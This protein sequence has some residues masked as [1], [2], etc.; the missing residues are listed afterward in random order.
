V[1]VEIDG[2]LIREI[3]DL[4]KFF[5]VEESGIKQGLD[6]IWDQIIRTSVREKKL[7]E[8]L[9]MHVK[10]GEKV[11]SAMGEKASENWGIT[12]L[13]VVIA[14]IEPDPRVVED[15]ALKEREKLQREGQIIELQHFTNRVTELMASPPTGA[16][17]SREQ[18][19]EQVQ[20]SLGKATKN[21]DA[22]TI[23][24]DPSTAAIITAIL[25]RR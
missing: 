22:K 25:G 18:A 17:L 21:I 12:I 20:M 19:I 14:G 15:L 6:D 4:D 8:V 10:L 16:G 11:F 7:D 2:T 5:G 3:K 24:L 9:K 13:R 1:Q 23:T